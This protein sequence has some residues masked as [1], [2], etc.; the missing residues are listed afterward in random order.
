MIL[1]QF[2]DL[3]D[4]GKLRMLVFNKIMENN[5]GG[6]YAIL[7]LFNPETFEA[8]R[9]EMIDQLVVRITFLKQPVF[10]LIII[11]FIDKRIF[12]ILLMRFGIRSEERRVGKECR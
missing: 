8:M 12:K 10:K 4:M 9:F 6:H 5:P 7:H 11:V 3:A 2:A 1:V